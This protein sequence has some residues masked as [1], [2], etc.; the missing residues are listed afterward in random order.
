M[1]Q[2][3]LVLNM[4]YCAQY[5]ICHAACMQQKRHVSASVLSLYMLCMWAACMR[6]RMCTSACICRALTLL[7]QRLGMH[8][9]YMQCTAHTYTW[10]PYPIRAARNQ[11]VRN[12]YWASIAV[13]ITV[14]DSVSSQQQSRESTAVRCA[15]LIK[16]QICRSLGLHND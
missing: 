11:C 12:H 3:A 2:A 16:L 7:I 14:T 8:G 10:L 6:M 9:K 4:Q 5:A 13:T 15:C 1:L